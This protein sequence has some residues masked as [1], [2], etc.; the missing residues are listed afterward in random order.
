MVTLDSL[1]I[2]PDFVKID[3]EG[4]ELE[5]LKGAEGVIKTGTKFAIACYHDLPEGGNE[6]NSV[7]NFLKDRGYKITIIHKYVFAE[8]E[9]EIA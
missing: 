2:Q 7:V 9:Q 8:K 5:I 4:S 1:R 6:L 3:A